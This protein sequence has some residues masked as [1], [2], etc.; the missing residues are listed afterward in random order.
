MKLGEIYNLIV[1]LGKNDPRGKDG[2][3]EF[4][5]NKMLSSRN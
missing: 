2:V 3:E 5:N 1:E 4:L